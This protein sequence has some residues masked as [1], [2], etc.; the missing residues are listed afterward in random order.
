MISQ[1]LIRHHTG[2]A[3]HRGKRKNFKKN[4]NNGLGNSKGGEALGIPHID[5]NHRA[6]FFL[7]H[8][9]HFLRILITAPTPIDT[10]AITATYGRIEVKSGETAPD[11]NEFGV[12]TAG[13][14]D[15]LE[16]FP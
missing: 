9:P 12:M 10:K 16:L 11:F 1:K 2:S 4:T 6:I 15:R 8:L 14:N 13:S 3:V 5:P 7:Y